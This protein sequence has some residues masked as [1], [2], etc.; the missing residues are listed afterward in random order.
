MKAYTDRTPEQIQERHRIVTHGTMLHNVHRNRILRTREIVST[1]TALKPGPSNII[2]LGCSV[3]DIS[4]PFAK[5]HHVIGYDINN[6]SVTIARKEYPHGVWVEGVVEDRHSEACHILIMC[7]FLEHTA[8]PWTIVDRWMPKANY[9]VISVPLDETPEVGMEF[10][11][12]T[13]QWSFSKRDVFALIKLGQHKVM[14]YEI[15]TLDH[16]AVGKWDTIVMWSE[17]NKE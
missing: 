9:A 2:E 15:I 16:G 10:S 12:G 3:G 4:G 17:R 13:H 7:E 8:G 14:D 11:E 6:H 5:D 1:L